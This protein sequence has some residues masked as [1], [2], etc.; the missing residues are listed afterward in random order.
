MAEGVTSHL[1]TEPPEDRG[2]VAS[3]LGGLLMGG[4]MK[5]CAEDPAFPY[6]VSLDG[7]AHFLIEAPSGNQY[8]II[9]I[10]IPPKDDTGSL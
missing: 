1:T 4:F 9:V 2:I 7:K 6:T 5:L 3:Y 8:R 10:P